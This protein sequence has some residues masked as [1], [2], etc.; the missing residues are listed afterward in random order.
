MGIKSCLINAKK[1]SYKQI[2]RKFYCLAHRAGH[3]II[4]TMLYEQPLGDNCGDLDAKTEDYDEVVFIQF[5]TDN[6]IIW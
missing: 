2:K 4:K 5:N 6:E 3:I 1:L